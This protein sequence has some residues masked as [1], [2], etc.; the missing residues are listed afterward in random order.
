MS[1][2][3]QTFQITRIAAAVAVAAVLVA[4]AALA[5]PHGATLAGMDA[6]KDGVVTRQEL[7]AHTAQAAVQ[8]DA[9]AD[10]RFHGSRSTGATTV[11]WMS[12]PT[13]TGLRSVGRSSS[14]SRR[15]RAAG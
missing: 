3:F 14:R 15:S 9:D 11:A 4:G 13:T 10:G 2:Q 8:L 6:D 12:P 1:N 5:R 7:A